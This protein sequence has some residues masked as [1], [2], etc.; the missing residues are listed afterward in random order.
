MGVKTRTPAEEDNTIIII[1]KELNDTQ[2][3]LNDQPVIDLKGNVSNPITPTPKRAEDDFIIVHGS[4]KNVDK[5][6]THNPSSKAE[7]END[8]NKRGIIEPTMLNMEDKHVDAAKND[9][10]VEDAKINTQVN[11]T[12]IDKPHNTEVKD[13]DYTETGKTE[14]LTKPGVDIIK[15][16]NDSAILTTSMKP[17]TEVVV[18]IHTS[19]TTPAKMPPAEALQQ[20]ITPTKAIEIT[21]MGTEATSTDRNKI[22]QSTTLPSKEN[23]DAPKK[24]NAVTYNTARIIILA[25]GFLVHYCA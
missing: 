22:V 9:T 20:N 14:T 16:V 12:K 23:K 13:L 21:T 10:Q 1:G 4:L 2:H 24:N 3:I 25:I 15:E 5:T 18:A 6:I 17:T 7:E 19:A 11:D 8:D